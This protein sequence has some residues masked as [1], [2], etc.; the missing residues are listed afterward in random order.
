MN[1]VFLILALVCLIASLYFFFYQKELF[2]GSVAILL[3][4]LFNLTFAMMKNSNS[5]GEKN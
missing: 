5:T 1:R 3:C 4:I 2:A